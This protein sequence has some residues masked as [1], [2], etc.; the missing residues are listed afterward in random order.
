MRSSWRRN[1]WKS[2][3]LCSKV[4][5]KES[6]QNL[7][8]GKYHILLVFIPLCVF[9]CFVWWSCGLCWMGVPG[10]VTECLLVRLMDALSLPSSFMAN[11]DL[12]RDTHTNKYRLKY[13]HTHTEEEKIGVYH[14]SHTGILSFFVNA[15]IYLLLAIL[16]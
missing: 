3:L 2:F 8:C 1:T 11:V 10:C 16:Q 6:S 7:S 12:H 5:L 9:S 4:N 15:Y 14:Y 13:T